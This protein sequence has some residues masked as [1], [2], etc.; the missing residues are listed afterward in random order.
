[1]KTE[2][3]TTRGER[4]YCCNVCRRELALA[5]VIDVEVKRGGFPHLAAK[6]FCSYH[7]QPSGHGKSGP[8]GNANSSSASSNGRPVFAS[9]RNGKLR[10]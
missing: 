1:M 4:L 2:G 5:E 3:F 8:E 9:S 10:L 6:E 7:A